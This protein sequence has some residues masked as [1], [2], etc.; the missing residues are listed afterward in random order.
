VIMPIRDLLCILDANDASSAPAL[1]QVLALA[2]NGKTDVSLLATGPREIPP[3]S[4][5]GADVV[6]EI[7]LTENEKVRK[8]TEALVEEAK[9]RISGA[10]VKGGVELCLDSFRDVLIRVRHMA[11]CRDLV[12]MNR[13]GGVAGH[14]EMF[15]EEILFSAGR[16]VLL[17]GAAAPEK[18]S[19]VVI[20][21]DGSSHAARALTQAL[22]LFDVKEAEVLVVEGEKNLKGTVPAKNVAAHI[23]RHGVAAKPVE[24]KMTTDV[25]T[26][27]DQH[28]AAAGADL[29]VMGAFGRSRLRE[30]VLGGVT[31][32][33]TQSS[34]APILLAH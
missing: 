26:T 5:L 3:Y 8:R 9:S 33:L 10:R 34:S 7:F 22:H 14:S 12:V 32:K 2:R 21:W 4:M 27:I 16:P 19:K 11:L 18:I 6:G 25:A 15:F 30:F 28:A 17:P 13:P 31:R 1:D 23:E 20:A 29:I 24:L